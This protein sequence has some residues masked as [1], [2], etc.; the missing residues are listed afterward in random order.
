[1][2]FLDLMA[3]ARKP[4]PLYTACLL[5]AGVAGAGSFLLLRGFAPQPP[6]SEL[7]AITVDYPADGSV[8]PPE[9][10][11]PTFLWHDHAANATS[12]A[13]EITFADHT[14][15]IHAKSS[16]ERL[17]IGEIDP[18]TV[19]PNNELPKLTPEQ[20]TAH[21]W[22]PDAET[23]AAI[24][25]RSVES[26]A[27]IMV[28]GYRDR[29]PQQPV[30]SGQLK[31]ETSRDPVGAPVFYRDVPLMPNQG[32]KGVIRPLAPEAVGL[33]KW[34]LRYLDEP[35]SR[36]VMQKISTCANCHSFSADGKTLGLDVDGPQNDRGLY[37]LIPVVK[38]T[39]IRTQ[40]VIK[41]PTVRDPK[42]P[43]LRAAFMSQISPDGRYVVSTIDDPDA[44]K[45]AGGRTLED[46]YY[47]ANFLDYRFLQVFYPTRGILAWYDREAKRLQ[48]LAGA[49]L[50][51]YVQT[52]GVWSPDGKYIVFARA[53]AKSP[54][55]PGSK[56]AL[57]AN[58][59]NELQIQYDLYRIPFNEG[60][61]G[62]AEPIA[63]ASANGMSNS[64]AKVSPDG[65]WIVFVQC[66]N[67][68]VQRPDS[69]LYI[70][71]STGGQA[72]LMKCNTPLMNSW[73]TFSPNG[74][75]LAFSSKGRSPYT[76]LYLTHLDANGNDTPA[77]LVDNTTASNRAVNLPE[78][79]NIPKGGLEKIDPLATEFYKME[80]AAIELMTRNQFG[81]AITVWRKALDLNPGDGRA[82]L[83]LGYALR[84]TGDPL[85]AL[86][87]FRKACD[88][89]PEDPLAVA[90]LALALAQ[91]GQSGEAIANY[92]KSLAID[93]SNAG[94]QADL[95]AMLCEQGETTEGLEHLEK[96][97]A[98]KPDSAAVLDKLAAAYSKLGRSEDAA[99]TWRRAQDL[100]SKLASHDQ[101]NGASR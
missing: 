54:Y 56:L 39:A 93:S 77:I 66:R 80:N 43:R 15:G 89:S 47:V 28:T 91:D 27:V 51:R 60:Q 79:A 96:A 101:P 55:P 87:E 48:P 26:P 85:G 20:A 25:K 81:D 10:T 3:A 17:R 62:E 78:F 50:S 67:G 65:R 35:R 45:R 73:H 31:I 71:P 46:K 69:K 72:R 7:A 32:A 21:T 95:G 23:W 18:E 13:I 44:A 75:W 41:W 86:A 34:R 70:V 8:F 16:G 90:E 38:E 100:R 92:R 61:G 29:A 6:S 97:A 94:V 4:A 36:V 49:N 30:S 2:Q 63:G 37:A 57:Y 98:L 1:M 53:E 33:I 59:P 22:I 52:N 99:Q 42:V 88:L 11:P 84:Q 68:M 24:K 5:V 74:R 14:P 40:D 9:I 19:S 83:N 64:F 12:W 76:Q 58:D 82:H